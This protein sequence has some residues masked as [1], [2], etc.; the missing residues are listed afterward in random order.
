MYKIAY[1]CKE[2]TYKMLHNHANRCE[3]G[4]FCDK[5]LQNVKNFSFCILTEMHKRF[6]IFV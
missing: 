1:S 2:K 6:I 3:N 4:V 5:K